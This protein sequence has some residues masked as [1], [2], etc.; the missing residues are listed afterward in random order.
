MSVP[1]IPLFVVGVGIPVPELPLDIFV[2]GSGGCGCTSASGWL[3]FV[4]DPNTVPVSVP[5]PRLTQFS[6][7]VDNVLV[8]SRRMSV[9]GVT[10]QF[11]ES[12]RP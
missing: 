2:P 3:S 11:T 4:R 10:G 5:W 9:R 6:V 1:V 12:H 7:N 8:S